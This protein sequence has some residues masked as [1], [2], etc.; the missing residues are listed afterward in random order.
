M[1]N[2]P[3]LTSQGSNSAASM[4]GRVSLRRPGWSDSCARKRAPHKPFFLFSF[5]LPPEPREE[6]AIM[7]RFTIKRPLLC[8]QRTFARSNVLIILYIYAF[9]SLL[10]S[11]YLGVRA[12]PDI[13]SEL[14]ALLRLNNPP[15]PPTTDETASVSCRVWLCVCLTWKRRTFVAFQMP[16]GAMFRTYISPQRSDVSHTL[17]ESVH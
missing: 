10:P 11:S 4:P 14:L 9:K 12:R 2:N 6:E 17:E 1:W 16:S 3:A 13:L 5:F 15:S 7:D 8:N